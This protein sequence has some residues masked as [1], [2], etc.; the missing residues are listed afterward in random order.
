MKP[1]KRI[2]ATLTEYHIHRLQWGHG[3]EAVEERWWLEQYPEAITCFNGATAMKPW[4]RPGVNPAVAE[5]VKL[6]WGHGDEA[7]EEPPS[8]RIRWRAQR[9]FNGATAM[10]PWKSA[11]L[12]R[13]RPGGVSFNGATAMKPWKRRSRSRLP[14]EPRCFNGATAMKPWKSQKSQLLQ[15]ASSMLQW[16][17]GDE[18]VEELQAA[19]GQDRVSVASMGPRR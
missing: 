13:T 1:W 18:A 6:Q 10:K 7:V 9:G 16:G 11:V 4:K 15:A 17:H 19:Y 5:A 14:T 8:P 3:D 12:P 2:Q